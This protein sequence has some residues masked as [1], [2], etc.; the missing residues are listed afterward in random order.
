MKKSKLEKK[1]KLNMLKIGQDMILDTLLIVI[2]FKK[3]LDGNQKIKFEEG[4]KETIEWYLQNK[5]F[6]S[7][8]SKNL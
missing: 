6:L 7:Q 8:I 1:Q 4:L 2:K 5:K 3:I